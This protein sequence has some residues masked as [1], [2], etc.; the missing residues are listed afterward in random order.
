[1]YK[2]CVC[3]FLYHQQHHLTFWEKRWEVHA[4]LASKYPALCQLQTTF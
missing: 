1:M 4:A 2:T 3:A